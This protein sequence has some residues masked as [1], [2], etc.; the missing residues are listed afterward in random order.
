MPENREGLQETSVSVVVQRSLAARIE[1]LEDEVALYSR[2]AE[3]NGGKAIEAGERAD[4]AERCADVMREAV[5]RIRPM[6]RNGN[7]DG[8]ME[9]VAH[10]AR[11]RPEDFA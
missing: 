1:Q 11:M 3:S 7:L 5:T 10:I 8:A 2:L 4:A 6:I 9:A